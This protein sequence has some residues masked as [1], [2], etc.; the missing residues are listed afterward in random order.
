MWPVRAGRPSSSPKLC[1][2]GG[3]KAYDKNDRF[4]E[5]MRYM[6]LS[7]TFYRDSEHS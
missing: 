6:K 3:S 1:V 4:I 2:M 5:P 7:N